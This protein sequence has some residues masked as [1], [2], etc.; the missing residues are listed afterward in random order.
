MF[1]GDCVGFTNLLETQQVAGAQSCLW[2]IQDQ[3]PAVTIK[4]RLLKGEGK[5][6][7]KDINQD[8][9][10]FHGQSYLSFHN[11]QALFTAGQ[12]FGTLY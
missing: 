4:G 8:H 2:K 12:L 1:Q 7:V 11:N 10:N 5:K 3:L 9:A 6:R